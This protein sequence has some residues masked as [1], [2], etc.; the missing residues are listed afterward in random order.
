MRCGVLTVVLLRLGYGL[1]AMQ[2]QLP[3]ISRGTR[4]TTAL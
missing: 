1:G 4:K 2:T 3:S